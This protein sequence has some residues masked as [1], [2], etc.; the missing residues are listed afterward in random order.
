MN[1]GKEPGEGVKAGATLGGCGRW[2]S[3]KRMEVGVRKV[4]MWEVENWSVRLRY[5]VIGTGSA[6]GQLRNVDL[7][8]SSCRLFVLDT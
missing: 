1:G 4:E 8:H 5:L 3:M 6:I 7:S 2:S